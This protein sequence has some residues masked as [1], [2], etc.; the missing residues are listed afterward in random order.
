MSKRL[1]HFRFIV[2]DGE[3]RYRIVLCLYKVEFPTDDPIL[4]NLIL[5]ENMTTEFAGVI[6]EADDLH[7]ELEKSLDSSFDKLARESIVTKVS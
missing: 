5:V 2:V 7:Q 6:R 1:G 4:R 3:G